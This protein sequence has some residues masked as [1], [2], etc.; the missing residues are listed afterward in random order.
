MPALEKEKLNLFFEAR[1]LL[2]K[3]YNSN[4]FEI[5]FKLMPGDLMIMDNHRLLHGRTRYDS[6][7]GKRHLQGCYIDYDSSEGKL[8]HLQRKFKKDY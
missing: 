3:L 4:N 5:K 8:R 1:K 2:S 7:D 6:S